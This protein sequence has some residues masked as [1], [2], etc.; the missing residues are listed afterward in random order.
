MNKRLV[1]ASAFGCLLTFGFACPRGNAETRQNQT[2][3]RPQSIYQATR[4]GDAATVKKWLDR[5]VGVNVTFMDGETLLM[6]AAVDGRLE[7]TNLLL[8]RGAQVNRWDTAG[9]TA[10]GLAILNHHQAILLALLAHGASVNPVIHNA[11]AAPLTMAAQTDDVETIKILLKR[12]AHIDA[13]NNRGETALMT[14]VRRNHLE[15]VSLLLSG[16]ADRR[17]RN[18]DG[19]TA[20]SVARASRNKPIIALLE[21]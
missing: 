3:A 17:L 21:K 16:N 5:G 6:R 7:V 2:A 10:T 13:Q 4:R 8:R 20:L 18:R 12:H 15:A 9:F 14:A 1:Y 19:E 11:G